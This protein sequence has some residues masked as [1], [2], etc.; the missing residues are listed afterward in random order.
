MPVA[1]G[2]R[3]GPYEIAGTVGAGGMGEVYRARD[4]RLGRD[5]AVKLLP[6]SLAS[7]VSRLRRFEIEA[8]A[9]AALNHP[10][11]LA[12]YDIGTYRPTV[13]E[14]TAAAAAAQECP[15]IVGELLEGE[16]LRE[17]LRNGALSLRKAVDCAQQIARGL[18]AAHEKGIVHRDLKPENIFITE[19]GRVKIL[20]FGLA[21]LTRSE[22]AGDADLATQ[23]IH[24]E[25]G[26]VLGTVGY[27]SPEQVRGKPADAR[28]DLF[29][30]GAILYEMLS[31]K[32]AFHGASAAETMSAILNEEPPEL[33]E[34][35]RTV[36]PALERVVRHCLEKSAAERFQS[37]RDLAFDLEMVSGTSQSGARVQPLVAPVRWRRFAPVLWLIAAIAA[38]ALAFFAGR[39]QRATP[40]Q[41]HAL[42]YERG[43]IP[44]ARFAPDGQSVIYDASWEG[45][46]LRAFATPADEA[47]PRALEFEQA[48]LFSVSRSGEIAIGLGGKLGNHLDVRWA[49]LGRAPLAGGAPREVLD[50][51]DEADWAP[52][53]TLAVVHT[54]NGHDRI[55]FPVGRVL[56]ETNG[57]VTSLRISPN[58]DKIA[59]L[60]H[61]RWPDDA[62]TVAVV[63]LAGKKRTLSQEYESADGLAWAPGGEIWFTAA[64][65]GN[66]RALRAINVAGR[67]RTVLAIPGVLRLC[68]VAPNGR[69][70]LAVDNEKVGVKASTEVDK[71][72]RDLSWAGW[73]IPFDISADHKWLVFVEQSAIAGPNYIVA[74]RKL[75]GSAPVRLGEGNGGALSPD[76]K[77]V[78]SLPLTGATRVVLLPTGVGAAREIP[79]ALEKLAYATGFADDDHVMFTGAERG[80]GFR[81]WMQEISSG[82]LKPASPEGVLPCVASPDRA[83]V[84]A[85]GTDRKLTIY[86]LQGGAPRV[87]PGDTTGLTPIRWSND[88]AL[89]ASRGDRAPVEVLRVDPATGRQTPVRELTPGDAAGLIGISPIVLSP[90]A[91]AYAY[92]YRRTL[93]ELYVVDGLR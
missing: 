24:S 47:L 76:G 79:V 70:L 78:V 72:E 89:Y 39:G 41:F 51:V 88:G 93:S 81:C 18:A 3:F 54:V 44:N 83:Y 91:K 68:D 12:V 59:F 49:T 74:M 71:A 34:T 43:S 13:T 73:T 5:V 61:A 14:G 35:N 63:D 65:G 8:R 22:A 62:G 38:S 9:A 2:T 45:R 1:R 85:S 48:H 7:D 66:Y 87:I 4:T 77:W 67:E 40:P 26:T 82:K 80:H 31:G 11:L 16:T 32:R 50:N 33:T 6:A 56:Y 21:K 64:H 29:S 10:N 23:T 30:F 37:A 84:A 69:V 20:D 25:A 75:D 53:G 46:P 15:Y 42:T 58:G 92:S 57:W 60:D 36:P 55:E 17:R 90:D 19:D 86:S 27:M 52:D 28:S